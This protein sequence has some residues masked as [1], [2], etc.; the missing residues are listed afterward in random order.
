MAKRKRKKKSVNP[1]SAPERDAMRPRPRLLPV[2]WAEQYVRVPDGEAK[3]PFRRETMPL[4]ASVMNSV[5][6]PRYETTVGVA[7]TQ[8]GKS[9]S[10]NQ[11][12]LGYWLEYVRAH[13]GFGIPNRKLAQRVY[14]T[15]LKP[16]FEAVPSLAAL[17]PRGGAGSRGGFPTEQTLLNGALWMFLGAGSAADMSQATLRNLVIDETDKADQEAQAGKESNPIDQMVRRTDAYQLTRRLVYTCTPTVHHG[18]IWQAY[19]AGTQGKPWFRCIHCGQWLWFE[20]SWENQRIGW[21]DDSSEVAAMQTAFY[22]CP[23]CESPIREEDRIIMLRHPLWVHEG[24]KIEACDKRYVEDLNEIRMGKKRST[25]KIDAF[26]EG[27]LIGD[28]AF[29]VV[30]Q[31]KQ[32][33]SITFWWNRLTSPFTTIG[34]LAQKVRSSRDEENLRHGV[35]IYDMALPY[36]GRILDTSELKPE[37]I[38]DRMRYSDYRSGRKGRMPFVYD[39]NRVCV[40]GGIDIGKRELYGIF[41]A[42]ECDDEGYCLASWRIGWL[43]PYEYPHPDNTDAIFRALEHVR[44]Y[45]MRG[46]K[47]ANGVDFYPNAVG[48]DTGYQHNKQKRERIVPADY[49]VYRFVRQYGQGTWRAVDGRPSLAGEGPVKREKLDKY[50]VFLWAVDTDLVKCEIHSMLRTTPG[51]PGFWHIP[52]DTPRNY[53]KGLCAERRVTDFDKHNREQAEWVRVDPFNHPLDCEVYSWALARSLGVRPPRV[54][55][56]DDDE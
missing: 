46:W 51:K 31:R 40:T 38:L 54:T 13:S 19:E 28:D 48:I 9:L 11:V 43:I 5:A 33:R 18:Y 34:H 14:K 55:E 50:K 39:K 15:K 26:D 21:D 23:H 1:F 6:D 24:E 2:D 32:T 30:G 25:K 17:L 12:I 4:L 3:G 16:M 35:C 56:M 53:A 37:M 20:W 27:V 7:S 36:A 22:P 52:Q 29:K 41:D 47:D 42:W 49:Q 8:S 44:S 10:L 45:L